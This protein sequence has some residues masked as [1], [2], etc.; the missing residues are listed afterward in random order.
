MEVI[1]IENIRIYVKLKLPYILGWR[2]W[3]L[4]YGVHC[5]MHYVRSI[6]WI[7]WNSFT[8]PTTKK[9]RKLVWCE[10]MQFINIT[11]EKEFVIPITMIHKRIIIRHQKKKSI[12]SFC[13]DNNNWNTPCMIQRN[14]HVYRYMCVELKFSVNVYTRVHHRGV[15][16]NQHVTV[17]KI[18]I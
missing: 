3:I 1:E 18:S 2:G 6:T 4:Y 11:N 15:N 16:K 14:I 7:L 5:T 9:K 8:K 13:L 10:G 17:S 12:E